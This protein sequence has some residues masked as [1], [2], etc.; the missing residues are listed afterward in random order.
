MS[1]MRVPVTDAFDETDQLQSL[2]VELTP[3]QIEWLEQRAE[4]R[5]LSLDHMLR[6]VITAQIRG[7]DE[8]AASAPTGG[9]GVPESAGS[10]ASPSVRAPS[11]DADEEEDAPSIVESLRAASERLQDLT[12]KETAPT[13]EDTSDLRDTIDRLQDRIE[14]STDEEAA[15]E[16]ASSGDSPDDGVIQDSGRSMFDMVEE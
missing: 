6:S 4:E 3:R 2:E 15:P 12:D 13:T 10:E 16:E 14:T 1:Q 5:G 9:D 7:T 8:T 11:S